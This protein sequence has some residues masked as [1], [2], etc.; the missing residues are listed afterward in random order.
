VHAVFPAAPDPGATY[1][2]YLHGR[3]IEEQGRDAVSQDFGRYE[4]DAIHRALA[5]RG[6]TV[7]G[8]VRPR[9]TDVETAAAT[10]AGELRRLLA[11]DVP[12]E[13]IT[14]V[15]ASKGA[16]IAMLASTA[17]PEPRVRWV[18]LANCN[19]TVRT[20]FP[21]ALHGEVLSLYESSDDIGSSCG[22]L[23]AGSPDLARSAEVRLDTGLRH[24][25]L[26]RPL[27]AW[28]EPALD[29]AHRVQDP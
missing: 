18:L 1:V 25:F 9:G 21:L 28:V 7:I 4:L 2:I 5:A 22:S 24:G 3:I 19:D 6:A 15:G 23:F 27:P 20:N 29:W 14:V 8:E 16:V 26:Y 12:P 10:L 13:R 17:L 11:A